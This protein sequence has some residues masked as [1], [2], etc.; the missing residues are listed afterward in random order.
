MIVFI[1]FLFLIQALHTAHALRLSDKVRRFSVPNK[2]VYMQGPLSLRGG[3]I[4][5]IAEVIGSNPN[6]L[7]NGVFAGLCGTAALWKMADAVSTKDSS[8]SAASKPTGVR[9]LQV[10]F[11]SVFWLMRMAGILTNCLFYYF[12]L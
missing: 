2:A 6:T 4:C 5:K 10:K 3:S 9:N 12:V 7:F 1:A 11:L 8:A